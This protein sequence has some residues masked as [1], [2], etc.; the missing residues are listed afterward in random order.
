M[1]FK[2]TTIEVDGRCLDL[3][4]TEDEIAAGFE[5]CLEASNQKFIGEKCCACWPVNKPPECPFWRKILGLC[6]Q[7]EEK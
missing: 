1:D 6:V 7:C 3:L 5:R 4:L 2:H